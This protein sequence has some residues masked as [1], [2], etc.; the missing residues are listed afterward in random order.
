MLRKVI[1]IVLS[2]TL[3]DNLCS[4]LKLLINDFVQNFITLYGESA[5]VPKF[6]FLVHYPEQMC[7]LGP[8]IHSWTIWY[9]AKLNYF[10]QASHLINLK[11]VAFSLASHHQ[12]LMC[13]ELSGGRLLHTPVECGP[14][15]SNSGLK[16]FKDET[17]E[18]QT[19][20][21]EIVSELRRSRIN[22]LSTCMG[23]KRWGIIQGQ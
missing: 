14:P 23:E 5:H 12:K 16:L 22:N 6:H 18:T 11:N 19:R 1:D 2:P 3:S 21:S 20:L 10:K 17:T 9:E 7:S 13:Y 4:S 15:Q 8:M